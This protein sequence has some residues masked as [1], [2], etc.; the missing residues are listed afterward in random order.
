[1]NFYGTSLRVG[2]SSLPIAIGIP[3]CPRKLGIQV[4]LLVYPLCTIKEYFSNYKISGS[5]YV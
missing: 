5:S 4:S 1:M 3:A 2:L